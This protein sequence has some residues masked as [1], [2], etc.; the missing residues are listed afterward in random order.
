MKLIDIISFITLLLIGIY[1]CIYGLISFK[2]GR[3][4]SPDKIPFLKQSEVTGDNAKRFAKFTI[5]LG[6]LIIIISIIY[7]TIIA[8][9]K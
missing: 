8:L 5:F 1:Y 2:R 3:F 4:K 9:N 7:F 6:V